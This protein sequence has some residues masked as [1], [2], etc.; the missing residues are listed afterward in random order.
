VLLIGDVRVAV[1]ML[2]PHDNA[3][4]GGYRITQEKPLKLADG[5]P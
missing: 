4:P 1:K 2:K 5:M 3:L